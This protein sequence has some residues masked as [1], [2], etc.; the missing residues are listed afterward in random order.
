MTRSNLHITL[1]NGDRIQCVADSSSAPEQGYIVEQLLLPLL[2]LFDRDKELALIREHCTMDEQRSNADYRY[3]IDLP[4]RKIAFYEEN[5]LPAKDSF[6]KGTMQVVIPSR[7]S[8]T[9]PMSS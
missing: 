6:K 2:F 7:N 5:Y 9:C 8:N 4:A 1:S 3:G